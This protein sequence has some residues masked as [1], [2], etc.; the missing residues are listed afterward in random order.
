[1]AIEPGFKV[2]LGIYRIGS[3]V[4]TVRREIWDLLAPHVEDV[5][6]AYYDN[7]LVHAPIYRERIERDRP[8]LVRGAIE[9]TKKLLLEPWD[10]AWVQFAY[11]RA[12]AE[13]ES[14][15]DLRARGAMAIFVL[16]E[17]DKLIVAHHRFSVK[18]AMRMMK[19]AVQVFMLDAANAVA[20]H[21]ALETQREKARADQLEAAIRE[22]GS[23]VDKVRRSVETAVTSIGSTS[24]QLAEI[25]SAAS[26]QAITAS[27]AAE[28]TAHRINSIATA[29][30]EL[31]TT[32]QEMRAQT[33][34]SAKMTS[35]AVSRS[36]HTSESI[37]ALS[38]AAEKIGSVVD[39]IA[40]IAGQTNLLALNATI[41]AAR[42]GEMG[43]GFA[44]VALEIKSL[45]A[46]TAKATDDIAQQITQVQE[47]TRESI[48]EITSTGETITQISAIAEA[49]TTA[50]SQQA[51]ATDEI[52]QNASAAAANAA[53]VA[54]ALKTV[55]NTI[56]RA[57]ETTLLVSNFSAD[58][59]RRS[60]EIG[61]A[62]DRLSIVASNIG[63]RRL[64]NLA[65]AS[66]K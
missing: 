8:Q 25:A 49:V 4:D 30:E 13:I 60:D 27:Q 39:M 58:L 5:L 16:I 59:L 50:A 56:R 46:Q 41:E 19:T 2:R 47:A 35:D 37:S 54:D 65:A 11:T 7:A 31:S 3:Q 63:T 9:A 20:C 36:Q 10:E 28:N 18:K 15:L 57:E 17:L 6:N 24:E 38:E 21:Y 40:K 51:S 22:F 14:G 64:A 66:N 53:T 55:G 12:K 48:G 26:R 42:A 62:M 23:A 1:M 43:K 29:T 33:A 34:A 32:V 45:A 61:H 44:V 52:A